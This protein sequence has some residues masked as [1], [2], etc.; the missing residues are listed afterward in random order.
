MTAKKR[1][2]TEDT[3]L[4]RRLREKY[5]N[6]SDFYE[7][8]F[9]GGKNPPFSRD[10]A[11]RAIY[12]GRPVSPQTLALLMD[13]LDF[14]RAEIAERLEQ[15]DGSRGYTRLIEPAGGAEGSISRDERQVVD[16]LRVLKRTHE[17]L[18]H[19]LYA[20]IRLVGGYA[21]PLTT[22]LHALAGTLAGEKTKDQFVQAVNL[23][24]GV[25]GIDAQ[26]EYGAT[27]LILA[28]MCHNEDVAVALIEKGARVD[29]RDWRSRTAVD[30][31][32]QGKLNRVLDKMKEC[33]PELVFDSWVDDS[34]SKKET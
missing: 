3:Q 2:A 6:L 11:R 5:R 29:I 30:H 33:C 4:M 9:A 22:P 26:N 16:D 31:A 7:R 24:A 15:T 17:K 32:R 13:A 8:K 1:K 20:F 34:D 14:S 10:T 27:P 28:C 25:M 19:A 12:E 23:L 18:H 21:D